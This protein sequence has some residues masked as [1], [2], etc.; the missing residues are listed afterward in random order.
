MA[1]DD[2]ATEL[3]SGTEFRRARIGLEGS[4]ADDWAYKPNT[5]SAT[6]KPH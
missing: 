2:D 3:G 5:N 4:I 1:A 6:A